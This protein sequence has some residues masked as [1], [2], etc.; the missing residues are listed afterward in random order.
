[1]NIA[2]LV[3]TGTYC[4]ILF[5]VDLEYTQNIPI[6][7]NNYSNGMKL[8]GGFLSF[9]KKIQSK[10]LS[11]LE[12]YINNSTQVIIT[13]IS[14]GGATS[15]LAALDLHKRKLDNGII[16]NNIIHYSFAS[17]RIFNTIGAKYYDS[18]N[19]PSYRIQNDTDIITN[20]PFAVMINSVGTEDFTHIGSLKFFNNNLGNYYDNH[21]LA[22]LLHYNIIS[23]VK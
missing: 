9:Y 11:L 7:I 10:L 4:N 14:L 8:H 5:L 6:G 20:V 3:F 16:I 21:I 1:M 23:I 22:Y 17:P 12:I 13:G 15:T 19:I 2:I 18:L